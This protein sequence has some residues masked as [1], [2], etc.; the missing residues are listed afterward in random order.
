MIPT[1][2]IFLDENVTIHATLWHIFATYRIKGGWRVSVIL[3]EEYYRQVYQDLYRFALYTLGNPQDAEDAV[4]EAVTDAYQGFAGLKKQESFRP[5][6]FRILTIK[7]KR[8]MKEYVNRPVQL[9][10]AEVAEFETE[11][12]AEESQDVRNAYFTL[13]GQERLIIS[14]SVFGGYTSRE[15][16]KALMLRD[17]TVRSKLSRALEKMEKILEP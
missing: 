12:E 5:W 16:G 8:K 10:S 9:E 7:C 14:L 3:F 4:S 13:S 2:C 6:M 17:T 1:G 11:W 15:I